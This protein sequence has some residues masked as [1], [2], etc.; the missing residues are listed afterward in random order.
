M[1][2]LQINGKT[3][4]IPNDTEPNLIAEIQARV[5]GDKTIT[6]TLT[7]LVAQANGRID[8]MLVTLGAVNVR[9]DA[10]ES[11]EGENWQGPLQQEAN[12]RIQG[13][14]NLKNQLDQEVSQR[15]ILTDDY[16]NYKSLS[17][18]SVNQ[19]N[20]IHKYD[21]V[22]RPRLITGQTGQVGHYPAGQ[23]VS[24]LIGDYRGVFVQKNGNTVTISG[25]LSPNTVIPAGSD[26]VL[27]ELPYDCSPFNDIS[28]LCQGSGGSQWL[29]SIS[30]YPSGSGTTCRASL[31]RYRNGSVNVDCGAGSWLPIQV[32][33]E[34]IPMNA[35]GL[36]SGEYT[37]GTSISWKDSPDY[38]DGTK[39]TMRI[40]DN[41]NNVLT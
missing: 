20:M 19:F 41:N 10:L 28:V 3:I 36:F 11:G 9:L 29:L 24:K 31:G 13:D 22:F 5:E 38:P 35:S 39:T 34:A 4:S 6:E 2:K 15:T 23:G 17:L 33:Y 21:R 32:S 8:N 1:I 37:Y 18:T 14:T 27:F 7:T 16:L 40:T 26:V 30:K 25:T 12:R